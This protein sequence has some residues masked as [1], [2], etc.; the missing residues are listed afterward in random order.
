MGDFSFGHIILLVIVGIIVYGKDL[1]Q[2][3]RKLAIMYNKFR[4]QIADIKDE[5]QR[6]IPM[7][8][9]KSELNK[10]QS[11]FDPMAPQVEIPMSPT[12]VI[13]QVADAGKVI[14]TWNSVPGATTYNLK[15]A[16]SSV[17]PLLIV[18]MNLTDLSYADS[19]LEP[20]KTYHYVV[21]AQN[22]AGE[23]GS[24]EEGVVTLPAE[25][26]AAPPP[27]APPSAEAPLP[28][29]A[30]PPAPEVAPSPGVNGGGGSAQPA[31]QTEAPPA[32]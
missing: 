4:R 28:P 17:D 5:I 3:A 6:Q 8:E 12:S 31:A 26:A 7:D 27:A 14:V 10:V 13:A 21:T 29:A 30:P 2:A 22:S 23:S 20:G 15:R 25:I 1:P 24:S 18:A 11:G 9:I 16:T 32:A 19:G